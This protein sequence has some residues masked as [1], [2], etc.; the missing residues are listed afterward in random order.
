MLLWLT[1][2]SRLLGRW[3]SD[4]ERT[5]ADWRF[6]P[7]TP[8]DQR[9]FVSGMFGKLEI[10]YTRWR[11]ESLFEGTKEA[12]WYRVLAKD[13]SSVMIRSWSDLPGVGRVQSLTHVHFEG[14]YYWI[15]LGTSNTREFFRRIE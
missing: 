6:Q 13:E 4:R 7:D 10:T 5:M 8:E 14:A 11:C 15:T 2:D 3:K 12:E 1:G 9:A